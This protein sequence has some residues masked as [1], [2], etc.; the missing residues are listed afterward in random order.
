MISAIGKLLANVAAPIA[1]LYAIGYLAQVVNIWLVAKQN[2]GFRFITAWH[3]ASVIDRTVMI[4]IGLK[5]LVF[6]WFLAV[7]ILFL[8]AVLR[9]HRP[10]NPLTRFRKY[11][12][13]TLTS[14]PAESPSA[15]SRWAFFS[16]GPIP[17]YFGGQVTTTSNETKADGSTWWL[18]SILLAVVLALLWLFI[19]G[20]L[21]PTPVLKN[22]SDREVLS[23]FPYVNLT[24]G[25]PAE[26]PSGA[27]SEAQ[28]FTGTAKPSENAEEGT[29]TVTGSLDS[30]GGDTQDGPVKPEEVEGIL[31]SH[32]SDY[33]YI[34]A[35]E[36]ADEGTSQR[37][38][39]VIPADEAS[40]V[41]VVRENTVRPTKTSAQER[42]CTY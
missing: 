23:Y 40:E 7:V 20:L 18:G 21:A 32:D 3:V 6:T 9:R 13:A 11:V 38:I 19:K 2:Y 30:T 14:A 28:P 33:W 24:V 4:G 36:G 31:L 1:A 15:P 41:C 22:P 27:S 35:E 5:Y 29:Y 34:L 39:L 42:D 12:V 37:R 26:V 16:G 25:G 8:A 17:I 10:N